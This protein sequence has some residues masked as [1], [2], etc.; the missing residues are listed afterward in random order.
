MFE[1]RVNLIILYFFYNLFCLSFNI[2]AQ[3]YQITSVPVLR[4]SIDRFTKEIYYRHEITGQIF[5][6]NSKGTYHKLTN[7]TS[8]P[9]FANN[10]HKAA[11]VVTHSTFDK[12]IY[13]HDFEKDSSYFLANYDVSGGRGL[14]ISPSDDKI[15]ILSGS[16]LYYS[17]NDSSLHYPGFRIIGGDMNWISDTTVTYWSTINQ[18][19]TYNINNFNIDTLVTLTTGD[20]RGLAYNNKLNVMAY[21]WDINQGDNAFINL[22]YLNSKRDTTVYNYLEDGPT[23]GAYPFPIYFEYLSWIAEYGKLGFIG[24]IVLNPFSFIYAFDYN[25]SQTYLYTDF[26]G[27]IDPKVD[28]NWMN[29]D[30]ML[31]VS[32]YGFLYGIDATKPVGVWEYSHEDI[33][34]LNVKVYPNPFNPATQIKYS[35]PEQS[36][37]T[38]KIFDM[39]GNEIVTLINAYKLAGNYEV[40]FNA[41]KYKLSSG[42]YICTLRVGNR[43]KSNKMIYLK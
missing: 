33:D 19:Y 41:S 23:L 3:E 7:F 30:T 6:T 5:K 36:L 18:I 22:Y 16:P 15:M 38:V 4:Y 28:L 43:L 1:T 9:A 21:S 17:F 31:Y 11:Y 20:I 26:N 10:S 40:K 39:L 27:N 2:Y 32:S 12:D 8:V 25:S 24:Q 29:K 13:I 34:Q 37:V 35:I 42:I 14:I